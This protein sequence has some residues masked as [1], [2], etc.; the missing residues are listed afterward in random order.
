V[1]TAAVDRSGRL[2]VSFAQPI[3]YV[4]DVGGDK[5]R[6]VQ[7]RGAGVI[8]P[9]SLSFTSRATVLVTP[10]CYEFPVR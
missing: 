7:F 8:A 5:I 10:G 3:T 2:W 6:T 4:Y 1:R 9:S